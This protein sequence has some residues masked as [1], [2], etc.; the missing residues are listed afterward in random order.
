M[1]PK[2]FV[3]FLVAGLL[4][5]S[6]ASAEALCLPLAGMAGKKESVR[7]MESVIDG[8]LW[9][10][11]ASARVHRDDSVGPL[12]V[13]LHH[14]REDYRCAAKRLEPFAQGQNRIIAQ[15]AQT[16]VKEYALLSVLNEN[17]I[18][19]ITGAANGPT[20]KPGDLLDQLAALESQKDE[21][22]VAL[23]AAVAL[24]AYALVQW[25]PRGEATGRLNI[26]AAEREQ[27]LRLLRRSFGAE[28]SDPKPDAVDAWEAAGHVIYKALTDQ[29]WKAVDESRDAS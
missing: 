24:S 11:T 4:V 18:L 25:G 10:K 8:L 5:S 28:V 3:A 12:L 21:A 9:A 7:F 2:R 16:L 23:V 22:E 15:A 20:V 19:T 29:K 1:H 14:R 27:L 6:A 13:A 26:T 17:T